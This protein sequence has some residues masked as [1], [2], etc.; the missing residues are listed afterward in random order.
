MERPSPR[1]VTVAVPFHRDLSQSFVLR[2]LPSVQPPSDQALVQLLRRGDRTAFDSVYERYSTRLLGFTLRLSG[3]RDVAQDL[4]QDTWYKLASSAERLAPDTDP[5]GWLLTVAR[6]AY[7]DRA[8]PERRLR[9]LVEA[10]EPQSTGAI[11]ESATLAREQV[12]VLESA[13]ARLSD[14]DREVLLLVG[15]EELSHERTARILGLSAAALRKRLSRARERL[16][17][18][19]G[20]VA[21]APVPRERSMP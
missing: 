7:Y 17:H 12:T 11:A 16:Q 2:V 10:S 18:A 5:F 9:P 15:V 20:Q 14:I 13:L 6:N 4:F 3:N 19:M 21:E 8:R 1:V